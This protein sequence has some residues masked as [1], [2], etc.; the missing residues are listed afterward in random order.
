MLIK[1]T[2]SCHNGCIHCC[3]ECVPSDEHMSLETFKDALEFT[4]KYDSNALYGDEIAGGEPTEHPQFFE[5][6]DTYYEIMSEFKILTV[7]TNGHF[8]LEHPKEIHEYLDKY[9][10]LFFQVTYDNRYYPK[11]LD[12]TKRVLRHKRITIVTELEK[13]TPK[14]RAITNNLKVTDNVMAP[15]CMNVTL[16]LVQLNSKS[17]SELLKTLRRLN[18][19]CSPSIQVNG[20]IALGEFDSCPAFCSIYDSEETILNAIANNT[21]ECCPEI[22]AIFNEKVD[23]GQLKMKGTL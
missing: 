15:P 6:I 7:A 13:L 3:N 21:F 10:F 19:N 12:I 17:L 18:I 23:S 4:N 22:M 16:G 9:P 2:K 14:G 20:D 5:F 11:K 8:I 1:I